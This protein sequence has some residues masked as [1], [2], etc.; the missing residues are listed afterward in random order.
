MSEEESM[1]CPR[2]DGQR[3]KQKHLR[4]TIDHCDDCGGNF[5]DGGQMPATLGASASPDAWTGASASTEEDPEMECPRC[6][7]DMEQRRVAK[8]DLAVII[9]RCP[10]CEGIWLDGGEIDTIMRIG[11][12]ELA[13]KAAERSAE[14]GSMINEPV[15]LLT[16]LISESRKSQSPPKPD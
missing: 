13:A 5:F 1:L 4:A 2:C 16:R 7:E 12:K 3:K 14:R 9:D 8:D 6:E 15:D 10:G 11:A